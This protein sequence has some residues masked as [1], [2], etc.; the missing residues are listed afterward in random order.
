LNG[1]GEN[2]D[3]NMK[4]VEA[5]QTIAQSKGAKPGQVALA[6]L[7]AQGP[8]IVPI[9]GTKRRSYLEENVAA[10]DLRLSPSDLERLE[11]VAPRGAA[12]GGRYQEAMLSLLDR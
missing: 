1:Q 5:V 11:A 9:P 2:F 7:L 8:D 10:A 3:R 4:I 6:W 12:S